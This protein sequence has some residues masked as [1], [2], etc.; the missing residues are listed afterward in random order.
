MSIESVPLAGLF[1]GQGAQF[2]GMANGFADEAVVR[3]TFA[4]ASD[5][6]GYDTWRLA[7]EGPAERL[8]DTVFTQPMMLTTVLAAFRAWVLHSGRWPVVAAGHSLGELT[9][10]TAAGLFEFADAL[11]LVRRRA[12]LMQSCVP[13][14]QG[15]MAAVIGL[16]GEQVDALCRRL[17]DEGLHVEAVNFNEPQQTVIAGLHPALAEAQIRCEAAG[18]RRVLPLPVS[19]PFHTNLLL[20]VGRALRAEMRELTLRN[21]RFAVVNNLDADMR[22]EPNEVADALALQAHQPVQWLDGMHTLMRQR[23]AVALEFGPGRTLAGFAKKAGL[24]LRVLP[25]SDSASLDAAVRTV[26]SMEAVIDSAAAKHRYE[27]LKEAA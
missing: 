17:R 25:V 12:E 27:P 22:T 10:Y 23:P 14:G 15:G 2:A 1:P 11:R 7:A 13:A 21:A 16:S 9:A 24:P 5:V 6:L 18:A 19:A 8:N 20:P 3:D 4:E 26:E